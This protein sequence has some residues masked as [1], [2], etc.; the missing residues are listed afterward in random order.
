MEQLFP[1]IS[2]ERNSVKIAL[3]LKERA[4]QPLSDTLL[5]L[6]HTQGASAG[7]DFVPASILLNGKME[8]RILAI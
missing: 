3:S 7:Y 4:G 6:L 8:K 2:L 1:I 5:L